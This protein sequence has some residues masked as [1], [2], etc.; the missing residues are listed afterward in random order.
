M[1]PQTVGGASG[2][3]VATFYSEG[4]PHDK[5]LPLRR[6]FELLRAAFHGHCQSFHGYSLRRVRKAVLQD[7]TRGSDYTKEYSKVAGY[8]KYPNTGYNAI[9]FGA[10]KPFIILHV[11]E[12]LEPRALL[13]F[14]D[15][16]VLKHWNL[17]AYAPLAGGTTAWFLDTYGREGVAMPRENPAT[18]HVHICSAR[19]LEAAERSCVRADHAGSSGSSG[20]IT[21]GSGSGSG[22]GTGTSRRTE[23]SDL[24][25][26]PSPHSN[27]LAVR[28]QPTAVHFMHLT[29]TLTL[30]PTLTLKQVRK[31]PAAIHFMRLW[32]NAT[33]DEPTFLPSPVRQGGRWHTPEQCS[34][35]LLDACRHGRSEANLHRDLHP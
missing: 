17:A 11:L 14:M 7:G 10:F 8:L 6:P 32:L 3:H 20:T 30:T 15:T 12:R 18:R 2:F 13:L 23:A 1:R 19:A 26:L 9:G 16:N 21:T 31:Q 24:A 27:R 25:A 22:A 35:G 34:F 5:G 28:Q 29:L 4:P 33:R